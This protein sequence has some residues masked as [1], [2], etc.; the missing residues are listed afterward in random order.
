MKAVAQT[1]EAY[2]EEEAAFSFDDLSGLFIAERRDELEYAYTDVVQ[3][4]IWCMAACGVVLL[5][6]GPVEPARLLL[7]AHHL[8]V[9]GCVMAHPVGRFAE[10]LRAA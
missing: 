2:G 8:V 10:G 5:D 9:D 3:L 1:N 6:C 7:V 4:S